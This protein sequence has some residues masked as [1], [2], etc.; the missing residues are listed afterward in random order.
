MSPQLKKQ[1]RWSGTTLRIK[2]YIYQ[3]KA[4]RLA[5]HGGRFGLWMEQGTGK[6]LVALKVAA[7]YW[8]NNLIDSVLV[9]GPKAVLS[10]W[11]DE[12]KKFLAIPYTINDPQMGSL[13]FTLINYEKLKN[14]RKKKARQRFDMVIADESHRIKN[15]NS[16]QSKVSAKFAETAKY[17]LALSGTPR[18]NTDID[19]YAQYRFINPIIFGTWKE[20]DKE[21]LK[22]C[23]YMGYDRKFRPMKLKLFQSIIQE[24]SFR[25]TKKECLD[26]PDI[27]ET[28]IRIPIKNRK[29]YDKMERE[30]LLK[31][32]SHEEIITIEAP[33]AVTLLSK[34][35]QLASGFI[36]DENHNI[37]PTDE[38]KLE[39]LED[40]LGEKTIIFCKYTYEVDSIVKKLG[41]KYKI[42]TY[43]GRTKDK[44]VWKNLKD[45]D[46]MVAQI[47]SGGTGLNL[48]E[49]S[50][51]IFYSL[52]FSYIDI[53]QAKDRV[54][55]NGQKNK[56][57]IYYLL[58]KD[59]V[60]ENIYKAIL[61]KTEDARLI[62]D[63]LRMT[64]KAR[65]DAENG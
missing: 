27:T 40:L 63:D 57:T 65:L 64:Q 11:E 62:L 33:L 51:V 19:F 6:T 48:Q 36:Y 34:L 8:K 9:L 23:G 50:T 32:K 61:H 17:A 13:N 60:E 56:V 22:P 29:P 21:Y 3:R 31:F 5:I 42:L 12:I 15:R 14:Y 41:K 10:V 35:Q 43:D 47:K 53:S 4:A 55:R 59:T 28:P 30:L 16:I 39:A 52:S 25:I 37:I 58:A 26:L 38:T 7:Y 24:N 45:Y 49:A 44:S 54:Y 20:F 18:G 46:I 2:P 1:I